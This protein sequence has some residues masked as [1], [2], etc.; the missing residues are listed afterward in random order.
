MSDSREDILEMRNDDLR[1][2]LDSTFQCVGC[3]ERDCRDCEVSRLR[4]E[5]LGDE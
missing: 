1:E 5:A 2:V 3:G 4:R